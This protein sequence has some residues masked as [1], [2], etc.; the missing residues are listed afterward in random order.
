MSRMSSGADEDADSRRRA[1]FAVDELR[2]KIDARHFKPDV[3][4]DLRVT[5]NFKEGRVSHVEFDDR[6]DHK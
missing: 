4:G 2:R 6:S 1:D 3:W 5:L